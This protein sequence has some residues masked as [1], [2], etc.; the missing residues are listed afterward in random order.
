MFAV[1]P[2]CYFWL[3]HV[4]RGRGQL[5]RFSSQGV[6]GEGVVASSPSTLGEVTRNQ[7]VRLRGINTRSLMLLVPA[8]SRVAFVLDLNPSKDIIGLLGSQTQSPIQFAF[9]FT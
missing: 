5:T 2:M 9:K 1:I 7:F 8:E 6:W 4:P 3:Y